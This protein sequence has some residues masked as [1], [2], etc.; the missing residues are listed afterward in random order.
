MLCGVPEGFFHLM[1][2]RSV[3]VAEAQHM[4]QPLPMVP[5]ESLPEYPL[6]LVL[7]LLLPL[8]ILHG[9]SRCL[10]GRALQC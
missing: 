6:L 5:L 10:L 7:L 2:A 1:H 9:C 3:V 8:L 4:L